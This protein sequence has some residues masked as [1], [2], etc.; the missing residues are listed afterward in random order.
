MLLIIIYLL[1][2]L[3][4]LMSIYIIEQTRTAICES[5]YK[6]KKAVEQKE[7]AIF[8]LHLKNYTF[9]LTDYVWEST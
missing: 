2:N 8:L 3:G 1:L 7:V 6:E 4:D 5:M 9:V